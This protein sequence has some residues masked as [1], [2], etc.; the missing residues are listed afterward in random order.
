MS[1]LLIDHCICFEAV[2]KP[3]HRQVFVAEFAN[4]PSFRL[5]SPR[6]LHPLVEERRLIMVSLA[7]PLML[8]RSF[9]TYAG[10]C[11]NSIALR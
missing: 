9:S 6:P 10:S 11:L 5:C 8:V 4:S 7:R 2:A 1:A 3:F